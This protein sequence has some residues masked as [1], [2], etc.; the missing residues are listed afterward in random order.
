M[1]TEHFR[2]VNGKLTGRRIVVKDEINRVVSEAKTKLSEATNE[3]E[4]QNLKTA[5]VGKQ[6]SL[7]LLM[8]EMPKRDA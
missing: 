4:L 7:T 6:G 8:K 5:Y 3:K 2:S 1:F